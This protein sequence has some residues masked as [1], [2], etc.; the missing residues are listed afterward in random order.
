MN[1]ETKHRF[2]ESLCRA[3]EYGKP[4]RYWDPKKKEH[5]VM[6]IA[7][8][9]QSCEVLRECGKGMPEVEFT[10]TGSRDTRGNII[11]KLK[12]E[13]VPKEYIEEVVDV[14]GKDNKG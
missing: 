3:D 11:M 2:K 13:K 6:Q 14:A 8:K 5:Y 4:I 7:A 10:V 1:T 9:G 12:K